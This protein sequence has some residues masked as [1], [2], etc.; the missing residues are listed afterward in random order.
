[1]LCERSRRYVWRIRI[2]VDNLRWV[3]GYMKEAS[4]GKG[5]L[6]RRW[7]RRIKAYSYR[8][9]QNFNSYDRFLRLKTWLGDKKSSAII[10]EIVDNGGWD[11]IANKILRF[12]GK[13]T[14]QSERWNPNSQARSY[15]DVSR[16]EKWPPMEPNRAYQP[17]STSVSTRD[18]LSYLD[19]CLVGRFNDSFHSNPNHDTI[20]KWFYNRWRMTTG[21]KV[22]PI[23]HNLFLFEMPSRQEAT[24]VKAG[25]WFWN[26]RKLTLDWWTPIVEL[27][28]K[29]LPFGER[30][31]KV[32]GVPLHAW[33]VSYFR[34]IGDLC[35][36][37]VDIDEDTKTRANLIWARICIQKLDTAIPCKL[38]LKVADLSYEVW[39]I[40]DEHT[41][42]WVADEV[43]NQKKKVGEE[44]MELPRESEVYLAV[45]THRS[46]VAIN[47]NSNWP[48]KIISGLGG[49][50]Q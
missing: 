5:K 50:S 3:C 35:G 7:G 30:W 15:Y 44:E 28:T 9:H 41:R 12:L 36:G 24:R 29:K 16:M 23:S 48:R 47:S 1:M 14:T 21:L 25:K 40:P 22:S 39:V 34:R 42:I 49:Q 13:S 18:N 33:S 20:K 4:K 11:D 27:D 43:E 26:G 32:F 45:N 46:H 6:C 38:E 10:P 8:V 31:V 19:K 2:D 37:Y 17:T